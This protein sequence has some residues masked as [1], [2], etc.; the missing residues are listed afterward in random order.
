MTWQEKVDSFL[1]YLTDSRGYSS[2]T[3]NSYKGDLAHYTAFCQEQAVDPA[4]PPRGFLRGYLGYLAERGYARRTVARRVAALRSFFRYQTQLVGGD[5][6][7]EQLHS[8]KLQ[9]TLPKFLSEAQVEALLQAPDSKTPQ[10]C[11]DACI[12][13]FLYSTGCRVSELVGLNVEDVN[14]TAGCAR[15]VGKGRRERVVL[16]GHPAM[17]AVKRYLQS[18]RPRLTQGNTAERALFLNRFG[19]R[20]TDRSVRRLINKHTEAAALHL[21]ISPHTLRHTFATHLLE[22]GADLRS[23]QELLGH[24]NL[25]TTQ[26]YTHVTRRRLYQEYKAAHPR[27]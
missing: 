11:R 2:H 21:H 23:V 20:L 26:V 12:L 10:G 3:V 4:F 1:G 7:A 5:N 19:T 18:G 22:H 25:S 16:L 13:E 14:L 24:A 6:P 17:A 9:R 8:P 27:A 15:V